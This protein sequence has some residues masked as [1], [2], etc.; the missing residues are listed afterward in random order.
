MSGQDLYDD[1]RN[2]TT[3]L[4]TSLAEFG[5]RGKAY[6][7]AERIYREALAKQILIER[8][9]GVP[10]TIISDI[11]R[12]NPEIARLRFNKDVA[13]TSYK[14]AMEAIQVYKLNIRVLESAIER[15]WGSAK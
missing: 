3:L 2:N 10:V 13:E 5:K 9:K 1:L 7:D 4:H 8:D 11:C 14:A 15:E 6:A 12:G